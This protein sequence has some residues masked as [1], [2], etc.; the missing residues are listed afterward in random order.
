MTRSTI[1]RIIRH[2]QRSGD[3]PTGTTPVGMAAYVRGFLH[4]LKVRRAYR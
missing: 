2:G 3:L 4:G 1:A